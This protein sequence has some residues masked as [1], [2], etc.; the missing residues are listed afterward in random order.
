MQRLVVPYRR[1]D[2][3]GQSDPLR[4]LLAC[5][6]TGPNGVTQALFGIVD[7]G[8][9]FTSL[10]VPYAQTFGY[11]SSNLKDE[12]MVGANGAGITQVAQV[13]SRVSVPDFGDHVTEVF[14]RFTAG[15]GIVLWGRRDFMTD[16]HVTICESDQRFFLDRVGT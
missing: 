2:V 10:P 5:A 7:T 14:P 15:L 16:F 8:A 9:D 1:F 13:P 3:V 6:F 4:P 12:P 11:D